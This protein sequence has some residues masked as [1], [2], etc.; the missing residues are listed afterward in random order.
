M[1]P[2]IYIDGKE[3]TTGLQI[4]ERLGQRDDLELLL[5]D[6]DK[7][8][9]TAERKKFLNAADIVFLCLPDAAAKEAV[10]LIENDHTRVI[11]ASTAHRTA[12]GW[13]YGF[14]ELSAARRAA[15]AQSKRV[16]NPG[17][18]ASGFIASA[19]PLVQDGVVPADFT[20][21]CSSL[22]GYSGGG[23]KLIAEYEDANRDPRH[24]SHRIYGL[25]LQHKHLPEMQHVCGLKTA[26]VFVPILGDFYKGM[27]TTVMLPGFDAHRI[28]EALAK[29]YEG[30]KLVTVAPFGGI[31]PVIY[32]NTKAG[33]DSME[34]IVCGHETQTIVTALFDNLGKGASGAAVQNM[35]IMLGLDETTGL[36]V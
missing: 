3:G 2:K 26:P 5:I 32:A 11:D 6:E 10:S 14:A 21:T 9:D 24:D 35:N 13:D 31:E 34:L 28:H 19:Y 4:Y 16:A 15:I 18:H 8:K 12:V 25:S 23:K 17:C 36:S 20:F 33:Q 30:Q 7:R 29:H 1:K 22:T 27:A